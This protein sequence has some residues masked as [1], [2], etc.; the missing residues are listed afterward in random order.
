LEVKTFLEVLAFKNFQDKAFLQKSYFEYL[1]TDQEEFKN[2]LEE[3]IDR[4][5]F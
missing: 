2:N 5:V 3:T 4:G 1:S